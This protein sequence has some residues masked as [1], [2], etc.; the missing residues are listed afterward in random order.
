[1][2][3]VVVVVVLVVAVAVAVAVMIIIIIQII[4]RVPT[5]K[6]SAQIAYRLHFNI[7]FTKNITFKN[8]IITKHSIAIT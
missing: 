3:I 6:N 2:K 7:L 4:S 8:D 5:L 1:M